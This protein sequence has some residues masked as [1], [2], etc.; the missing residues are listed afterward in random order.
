MEKLLAKEE[1]IERLLNRNC[2]IINALV[3]REEN[4][5]VVNILDHLYLENDMLYKCLSAI[6]YDK[7][8]ETIIHEFLFKEYEEIKHNHIFKSLNEV[9]ENRAKKLSLS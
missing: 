5:K 3:S 8:K 1:E 2:I 9:E 7:K 4:E 6:E